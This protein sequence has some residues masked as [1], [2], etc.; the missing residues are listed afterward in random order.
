MVTAAGAGA[1]ADA[2]SQ[3]PLLELFMY[4]YTVSAEFATD[5]TATEWLHW[6]KDGHIDDVLAAG[7]T[8]AEIVRLDDAGDGI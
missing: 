1:A 4:R 5:A 7:A 3:R 8:S 2:G 6:L